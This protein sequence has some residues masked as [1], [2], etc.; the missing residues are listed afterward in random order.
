MGRFDKRLRAVAGARKADAR[1]AD[2][3]GDVRVGDDVRWTDPSG[4]AHHF[5]VRRMQRFSRA[6]GVPSR[7]LRTTGPHVLHLVTCTNRQRTSGGFR[8]ADNLD[9]TAEEIGR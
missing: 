3:A 5:V 1:C 4:E 9:V 7:L 2:G 8:Y 6:E